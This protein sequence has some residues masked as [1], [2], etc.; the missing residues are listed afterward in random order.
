MSDSAAAGGWL[1]ARCV[2]SP[3]LG[4]AASL[5]VDGHSMLRRTALC[6]AGG[7]ACGEEA[8]QSKAT[9]G[10]L[11]LRLDMVWQKD[12]HMDYPMQS[13]NYSSHSRGAMEVVGKAAHVLEGN[14]E[15]ILRVF[16]RL[17]ASP[18]AFL[19]QT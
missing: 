17:T 11:V 5:P 13:V 9:C 3:Q 15:E 16:W 19:L 8:V 12:P 14:T 4:P 7:I 2:K 6:R 10:C 1:W 18:Q